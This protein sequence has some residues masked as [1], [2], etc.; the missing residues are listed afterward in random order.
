MYGY[1]LVNSG[2]LG[3]SRTSYPVP[4]F[5]SGTPLYTSLYT[6]VNGKWVV[7]EVYFTAAS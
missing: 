6:L 3:P 4:K 1:N 5:P 2:V 7:Q